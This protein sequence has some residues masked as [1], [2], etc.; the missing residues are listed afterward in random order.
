[1][2]P[3]MRLGAGLERAIVSLLSFREKGCLSGT[4]GRSCQWN[5]FL[6]TVRGAGNGSIFASVTQT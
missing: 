4:L 3:L 5:E 6:G 1:M 2:I